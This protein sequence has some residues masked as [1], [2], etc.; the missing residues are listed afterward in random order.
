[1]STRRRVFFSG[2]MKRAWPRGRGGGSSPDSSSGG[3][4][5]SVLKDQ[6]E[7]AEQLAIKTEELVT[8]LDVKGIIVNGIDTFDED[9]GQDLL[10][11]FNRFADGMEEAAAIA[12]EMIGERGAA[13]DS[14]GLGARGAFGANRG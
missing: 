6:N 11:F 7:K 9:S 13:R 1:M 3:S 2:S 14:F 4:I 10:D 12:N 8:A 5:E